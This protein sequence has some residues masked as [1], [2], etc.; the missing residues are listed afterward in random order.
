MSL[1]RSDDQQAPNEVSLPVSRRISQ[2]CEE[3]ALSTQ[4]M[5]LAYNLSQELASQSDGPSAHLFEV[6]PSLDRF[7]GFCCSY[8]VEQGL[9]TT[10]S[11]KQSKCV[12]LSYLHSYEGKNPRICWSSSR[13]ILPVEYPYRS[14]PLLLRISVFSGSV[15][16]LV[17]VY[18]WIM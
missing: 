2:L 18:S 15:R 14:C 8:S 1:R 12:I 16:H 17:W 7:P 3:V 13:D 11:L 9:I 10:V 5:V 4:N 6:I